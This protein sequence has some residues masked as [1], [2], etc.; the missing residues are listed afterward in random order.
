MLLLWDTKAAALFSESSLKWQVLGFPSVVVPCE[1]L[2]PCDFEH[3]RVL[4][5]HLFKKRLKVFKA[6]LIQER[7]E[8]GS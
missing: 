5:A 2:L 7:I 4:K 6:H 3:I 8:N 1:Y